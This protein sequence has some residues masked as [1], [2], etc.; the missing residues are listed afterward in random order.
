MIDR[1]RSLTG[2]QTIGHA[3]TLDPFARGVLVVAIGR[4]ATKTLASEVQKE[5][6]YIAKIRLGA[7]STTDDADGEITATVD[8]VQPDRT[9][10]EQAL[11][12]FV[13]KIM[14]IPPVYSAIKFGGV[15]SYKKAR[16]GKTVPQ[17][18]REVF[19][20]EA[21]L[22]SYA[23]PDVTVRFVT[24]PG[25]YIRAIGRDLGKVLQ[26]GGYV[27]ELERTRVGTWEVK[28][29]LRL[30]PHPKDRL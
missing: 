15:R 2:E 18:L 3:G 11:H 9:A 13:G 10:V 23:W 17:L 7:A 28:D 19:V 8:P 12:G 5:K 26:T 21:E 25:V 6:E 24:G 30:P 1:L 29:A 16:Q 27:A 20:K 14:Q 4:E 22:L